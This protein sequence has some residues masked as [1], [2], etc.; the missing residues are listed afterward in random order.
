[1]PGGRAAEHPKGRARRRARGCAT[2]THLGYPDL[3]TAPVS[4]NPKK[5]WTNSDRV[6]AA[7]EA[8]FTAL[9]PRSLGA[10]TRA[11]TKGRGRAT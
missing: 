8:I 3:Y 11:S 10:I 5:T 2:A 7:S 6:P 4:R 9:P 1:M